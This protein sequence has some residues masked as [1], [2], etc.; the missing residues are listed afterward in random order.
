M[1]ARA[2]ITGARL[3]TLPAAAAPVVVGG[4]LAASTGDFATLPFLAALLGALWI[5]IGTNFANDYSDFVRGADTEE[6]KGS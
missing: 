5:Q 1:S 4:G 3:R 2:W 6:R